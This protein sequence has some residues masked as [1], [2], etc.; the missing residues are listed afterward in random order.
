[1]GTKISIIIYIANKTLY[2]LWIFNQK[3]EG[4]IL[5]P[6]FEI[7]VPLFSV[8]APT[9]SVELFKLVDP[10]PLA[11][12]EASEIPPPPA[13]IAIGIALACPRIAG[14][15]H[16]PSY[17]SSQE[18]FNESVMVPSVPKSGPLISL[19]RFALNGTSSSVA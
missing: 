2:I 1:M 9:E 14:P 11:P 15:Y 10:E 13:P 3:K 12:I 18:P 5:S 19:M 16:V 6:P 17:A 8:L 4:Y 7:L